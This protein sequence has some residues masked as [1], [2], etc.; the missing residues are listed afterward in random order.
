MA[1]LTNKLALISGASAGIGRATALALAREGC[2]TILVGR[3]VERL[4]ELKNEIETTWQKEAFV[5]E[6]DIRRK[7]DVLSKIKNLP[8]EWRA[9]DILINNAGMAKGISKM[10]DSNVDDWDTMID[11]NVKGLLYVTHAIVPGMIK[12]G[13]G[14]IVH[15]GSIAGHEVYPGGNIYCAT[16]HAVHAIEKGLRIDV[17]D[18]P[19]RVS[20]IDPGMVET[21]FSE[22]RLGDKEK[23]KAVYKGLKPLTGA[24]IAELIVF[25]VTRPAHVQIGEITVFPTAQASAMV[26][27]RA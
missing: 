3:R 20:S 6:L 2:R 1:I 22:V 18:T 24:D 7:E 12:R 25:V 27:H 16:K 8:A 15:L 23:A 13:H 14:D 10:Q 19:L 21:E 4:K 17:V 9:V 5:L 11:T 26:A